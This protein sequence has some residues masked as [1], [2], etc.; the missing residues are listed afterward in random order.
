MCLSSRFNEMQMATFRFFLTC[1]RGPIVKEGIVEMWRMPE[2]QEDK[3]KHHKLSITS[4]SFFCFRPSTFSPCRTMNL[5][6]IAHRSQFLSQQN[7]NKNFFNQWPH[8]V[9][10]RRC[11]DTSYYT[12]RQFLDGTVTE[13]CVVSPAYTSPSAHGSLLN[14]QCQSERKLERTNG[15]SASLCAC[16]LMRVRNRKNAEHF[17]ENKNGLF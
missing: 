1:A 6:Y 16:F 4:G 11:S 10:S 5:L 14:I 13:N 3:N 7:E 8:V 9:R 2:Q 15:F 17:L 12:E